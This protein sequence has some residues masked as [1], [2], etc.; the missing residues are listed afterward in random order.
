MRILAFFALILLLILVNENAALACD[1]FTPSPRES[2]DMADV[3]FEGEVLSIAQSEE[4]TAYT[5]KVSRLLKGP[6]ST[7]ITIVEGMTDCDTMF[8]RNV[9]Y[10][11]YARRFNEELS[12]GQCSGNQVLL[13]K[14][15]VTGRVG[16]TTF[17]WRSSYT[18][19]LII[20]GICV[21]TLLIVRFLLRG[22]RPQKG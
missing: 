22:L 18:T 4:K 5:F 8:G 21:A 3:V 9:V 17:T 16:M 11:V 15:A 12:S 19:A 2:F 10:R 13:V 6:Y 7:E 20:A 14:K 1:C